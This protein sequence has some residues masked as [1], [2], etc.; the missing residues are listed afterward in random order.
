M[1]W[2]LS[3]ITEQM[4]GRVWCNTSA[5]IWKVL[6]QL[7][8]T[9][10]KERILQLRFSL[11]TTRKGA[12]FVEEYIL[13]MKGI[14]HALIAAGQHVSDDELILYILGGL[15]FDFEFKYHLCLPCLLIKLYPLNMILL[16][17]LLELLPGLSHYFCMLNLSL[18]LM[19]QFL[20]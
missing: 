3:S 7:F 18:Y 4:L 1:S 11:Q 16:L 8:S 13:K 19:P 12:E 6:D 20:T 17:L 2:L 10:S 14:S 9:R 5:E 15:G